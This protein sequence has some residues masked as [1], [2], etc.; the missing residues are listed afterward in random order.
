M[1][2]FATLR[3]AVRGRIATITLNRPE[4][5]NAI[6]DCMPGEI[7]AAVQRANDDARVHAI[8]LPGAGSAWS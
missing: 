6:D 1:A 5:L 4:R 8:V 3:L 2:R 7:A